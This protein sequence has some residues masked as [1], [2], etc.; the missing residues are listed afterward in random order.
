MPSLE[1][2]QKNID[3]TKKYAGDQDVE[4]WKNFFNHQHTIL[5][6]HLVGSWP[7]QFQF[8]WN[9]GAPSLVTTT[10]LQSLDNSDLNNLVR[11]RQTDI[12]VGPRIS[13]AVEARWQG[14]VHELQVGMMVATLA[15]GDEMGHPFGLRKLPIL[16]KMNSAIKLRLLWFIGFIPLPHMHLLGS[17]LW[18]WSRMLEAQAESVEERIYRARL[19]SHLTM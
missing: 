12:Y 2:K 18:R 7:L 8:N 14:N 10:N 9:I 3:C 11:P 19:L 15:G 6:N 13:R 5:L 17:S 4:W 1:E 16:L